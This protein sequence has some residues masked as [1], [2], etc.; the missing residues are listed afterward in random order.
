LHVFVTSILPNSM[1][2]L[3]RLSVI[4]AVLTL[5][6][7][8]ESIPNTPACRMHKNLSK[9]HLDS[10]ADTFKAAACV[11]KTNNRL[12]LIRHRLSGKLDFPGGGRIDGVSAACTAHRET[13]EET[14]FNVEVQQF[15][16]QSSNGLLLFGC[17]TDAGLDVLPEVFDAPAWATVEVTALEKVDP[18][19]LTH[20]DLRFADDLVVLRDAYTAYSVK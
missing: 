2:F 8:S 6:G 4:F 3:F 9:V 1:S 17:Y 12:L 14:G 13:W 15:L 11:I 20:D 10:S 18:F 16:G 5:L 19:L 7:C